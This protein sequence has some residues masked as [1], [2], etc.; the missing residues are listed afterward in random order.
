MSWFHNINNDIVWVL[1]IKYK[2]QNVFE[3]DVLSDNGILDRDVS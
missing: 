2:I 1:S 3:D